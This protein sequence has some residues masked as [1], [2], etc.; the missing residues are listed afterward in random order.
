MLR[1]A[2]AIGL[3]R[4]GNG[5]AFSPYEAELRR[6]LWWQIVVLDVRGV[7]DRGTEA[8][9]S[10][11]SYNTRMP[12]NISD[13]EFGPESTEPLV[14]REGASD[15][16]FSLCTA[17]SCDVFLYLHNPQAR[18]YKPD[19]NG[20]MQVVQPSEDD[21]VRR[22]QALEERFVK[23]ADMNFYQS[24][25]AAHTVRLIILIFWLS[26]QYPFQVRQQ[27]ASFGKA[28]GGAAATGAS[29]AAGSG[30]T[31]HHTQPGGGRPR[32]R[33]SREHVLHT[34]VAIMELQQHGKD[35]PFA[36]RFGWWTE[37]YPQW[38]PLAVALAELCSQTSGPLVDRA[39]AIIDSVLEQWSDQIADTKAGTL[40]RPIKKL[41]KKARAARAEAQMSRLDLNKGPG[42]PA[43]QQQQTPA[44]TP[45]GNALQT[46]L[47]TT[48]EVGG[49][50]QPLVEPCGYGGDRFM[51][52]NDFIFRDPHGPFDFDF[53]LDLAATQDLELMDWT[54]WNEFVSDANNDTSDT[55]IG[56]TL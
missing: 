41:L 2:Q 24:A 5:L 35:G 21:M 1:L 51:S 46:G 52:P 36:E 14:D 17:M 56:F 31:G 27:H 47:A 39:W 29:A 8:M 28:T 25:L 49:G 23:G 11:D 22:V 18:F 53:N 50:M 37:N 48:A 38:H 3:H 16:T 9:I 32:A 13:S 15:T 33:V 54:N 40:L 6:R 10:I 42:E 4:D 19:M 34:A 26:L 43:T 12:M 55:F 7:E 20:T 44:Q 30:T 45:V